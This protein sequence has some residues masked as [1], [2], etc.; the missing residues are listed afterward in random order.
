[1][2]K[3]SNKL[4]GLDSGNINKESNVNPNVSPNVN[5]N[6]SSNNPSSTLTSNISSALGSNKGVLDEVYTGG[7]TFGVLW[8]KIGAVIATIVGLIMLGVGIYLSVRKIDRE[9]KIAKVVKIDGTD[10]PGKTCPF[11]QTVNKIQTYRCSV[12]IKIEGR[13]DSV[14]LVYTGSAPLSI[15]SPVNVYVKNDN[16]NDITFDAPIPNYVGYI[17]I[18]VSIFVIL[19]AWGWVYL[20]TRYKFIAFASGASGAYDL[21]S[22]VRP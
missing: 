20:T 4:S 14:D 15:N 9:T 3:E 5:P 2:D 13:D 16:P 22:G 21:I 7:A 6:V 1:M 19:I 10:L 18:G 8:A 17:L 12:T 11:Y